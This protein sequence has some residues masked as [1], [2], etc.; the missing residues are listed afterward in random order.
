MEWQIIV[1]LA[2]AIPIILLPVVFIWFLNIG[3]VYAVMKR[4]QARRA[5]RARKTREIAEAEQ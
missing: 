2:L 3:G 5:T 4:A 1:A